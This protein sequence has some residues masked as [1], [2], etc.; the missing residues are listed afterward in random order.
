M[1]DKNTDK[2][3]RTD[4]TP[5]RDAETL[6]HFYHGKRYSLLETADAVGCTEGTVSQWCGRLGIETRD[7]SE[8]RDDGTPD[9]YK[10]EQ[11]LRSLYWD[12]GLTCAEIADEYDTTSLTVSRWLNRHGIETRPSHGTGKEDVSVECQNCG[13]VFE[14]IPSRADEAKYCSRECYYNGFDMPTGDD[15]WSWRETPKYRPNGTDWHQLRERIRDRDNYQCQLCGT[16][17]SDM[18]RELDIHHLRRVRDMD[19]PNGAVDV[20]DDK[21]VS[22]CRSCH[23]QAEKYAPLL[24]DGLV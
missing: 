23:M 3:S 14:T 19:D 1:S 10:D 6:Q 12:D 8:A 4:C 16:H 9:A 7:A 2:V 11:T 20:S 21:L 17:E 13:D 15:H 18:T 22:L 5:W 24:P